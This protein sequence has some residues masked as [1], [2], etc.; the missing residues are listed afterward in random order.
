MTVTRLDGGIDVLLQ[1]DRALDADRRERLARF[2]AETDLAR[3]SWQR[4]GDEM[5]EPLALRRPALAVFGGI[6]VAVPPGAFLQA[7]AA[8]EAALVAAVAEAVAEAASVADL[9]AGSGTFALPLASGGARVRAV[10]ADAGAVA[11]LA[12]TAR[13]APTISAHLTCERRDLFTRPLTATELNRFAAVVIDPP[14]AGAP[15]QVKALAASS[16]PLIVYVSCNPAS[17]AR[18]A[19]ILVDAGLRLEKATPVDQFLWSPHL[20]VVGVFRRQR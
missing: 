5:S 6:S 19:R 3:L 13:T 12:L 10:D 11:A 9:F 4:T 7:S 16:V 15:A 17:F 20:E 14:R 8:G 2:A 18:D 1:C